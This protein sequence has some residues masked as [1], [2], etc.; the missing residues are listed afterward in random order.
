MCRFLKGNPFWI[1]CHL[2][3]P[4]SNFQ[5]HSG[6]SNTLCGKACHKWFCLAWQSWN[7]DVNMHEIYLGFFCM[8]NTGWF[9]S[10]FT[11]G[12]MTFVLNHHKDVSQEY[13]CLPPS[14][15]DS[16]KWVPYFLIRLS[17]IS[18]AVGLRPRS[19]MFLINS[20]VRGKAEFRKSRRSTAKLFTFHRPN[21]LHEKNRDSKQAC[22]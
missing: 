11:V 17:V 18:W 13:V 5:P 4:A 20:G 3:T 21:S 14:V 16:R 15:A 8:K 10:S 12:I 9:S 1:C 19:R 22:P 7:W 6:R 2:F